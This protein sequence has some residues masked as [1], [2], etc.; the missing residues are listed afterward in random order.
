MAEVEGG[1]RAD[2]RRSRAE[3]GDAR[4][5]RQLDSHNQELAAPIEAEVVDDPR[6]AEAI[7]SNKRTI[8]VTQHNVADTE[9]MGNHDGVHPHL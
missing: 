5:Q 2:F 1:S 9:L 6:E 4:S 7:P 3:L 8:H